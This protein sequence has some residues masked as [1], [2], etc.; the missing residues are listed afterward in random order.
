MIS[1]IK[2]FAFHKDESIKLIIKIN[3]IENKII[4]RN[5]FK[6]RKE[7]ENETRSQYKTCLAQERER[8]YQKKAA[9][10]SEEKETRLARD[11]KRKP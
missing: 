10:T 11:R 7:R 4:Y 6:K 2:Y 9:K 1:N 5:T 8:K 3:I